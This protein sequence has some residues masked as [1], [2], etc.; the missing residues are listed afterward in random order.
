MIKNIIFSKK[1][2]IV[3]SMVTIITVTCSVYLFFN[4]DIVSG[5]N[6][7]SV[8]IPEPEN[9][10]VP[11][12]AKWVPELG[13]YLHKDYYYDKEAK[14]IKETETFKENLKKL[15]GNYK[16]EES[17]RKD[18]WKEKNKYTDDKLYRAILNWER[19]QKI[20]FSSIYYRR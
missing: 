4:P 19:D 2:M 16:E 3:F 7:E 13:C 9:N 8:Y 1:F 12:K 18:E 5:I 10:D 20:G 15:K 14:T 6:N 11:D 17:F